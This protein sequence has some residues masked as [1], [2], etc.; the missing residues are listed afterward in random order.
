MEHCISLCHIWWLIVILLH[1]NCASLVVKERTK[2]MLRA[3]DIQLEDFGGDVQS[4]CI[5]ARDVC[6]SVN[7]LS[8]LCSVCFIALWTHCCSL[9]RVDHIKLVT[10]WCFLLKFYLHHE[11]HVVPDICLF[12]CLLAASHNNY[13]SDFNENFTSDVLVP[14]NK[15]DTVKF[16]KSTTSGSGGS[17]PEKFQLCCPVYCLPVTPPPSC[18]SLWHTAVWSYL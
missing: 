1:F 14:L 3:H 10:K 11:G 4:V 7:S 8:I 5:S 12:V 9:F 13:W 15:E 6:H 18:L 2:K 16:C 17:E